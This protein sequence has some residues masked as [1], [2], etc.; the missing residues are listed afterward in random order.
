MILFTETADV[1]SIAKILAWATSWIFCWWGKIQY[2][3]ATKNNSVKLLPDLFHKAS[4][5]DN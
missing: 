3:V 2:F 1:T 5:L 4:I